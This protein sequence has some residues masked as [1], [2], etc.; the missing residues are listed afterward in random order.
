LDLILTGLAYSVECHDGL[1]KHAGF[2]GLI[3]EKGARN[4]WL[5][6]ADKALI[7]I[8]TSIRAC[9]EH[10]FGGI[11]LPIGVMRTKRSG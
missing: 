9:V 1:L 6:E 4:H 8:K 5:R 3:R 2:E 7:R 11:S 10:V